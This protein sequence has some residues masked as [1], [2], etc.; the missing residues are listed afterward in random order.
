MLRKSGLYGADWR[1]YTR[2]VSRRVEQ[3]T[4]PAFDT[5][6]TEGENSIQPFSGLPELP[7]DLSDAIESLKLAILRHKT[8]GW[9]EVDVDAVQ[10][11]LDA[12]GVMM[13]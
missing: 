12:V 8:S 5:A 9:N 13:R 10:K 4:S 3:L 2:L 11:Y 6:I 7:D 1:A